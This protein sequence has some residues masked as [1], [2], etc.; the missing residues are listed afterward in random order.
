MAAVHP[1]VVA[2][3]DFAAA[4]ARLSTKA[5]TAQLGGL[6]PVEGEVGGTQ[7]EVLGPAQSLCARG[8]LAGQHDQPLVARDVRSDPF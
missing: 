5:G 8:Q 1:P 6:L 4:A 2:T 7:V 3:R